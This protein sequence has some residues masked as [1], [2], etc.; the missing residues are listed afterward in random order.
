MID[1][2]DS[3]SVAARWESSPHPVRLVTC[4][5]HH[6]HHH[7]L[8]APQSPELQASTKVKEMPTRRAVT[9]SPVQSI[10]SFRT[11][12]RITKSQTP[13][14]GIK[15]DVISTPKKL[16]AISPP[17][18]DPVPTAPPQQKP[19]QSE[20]EIEEER[21]T[22]S[23]G[24]DSIHAYYENHVLASRV[25]PPVHQEGLPLEEKVL[26]HFDLSL[27]YGPCIGIGR[28][29]RWERAKGLGM[30]PPLEVLAVC[31]KME[32]ELGGTR[33]KEQGGEMVGCGVER[34]RDTRRSYL[35]DF[36]STRTV[37]E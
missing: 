10:L 2:S 25:S 34:T 17:P 31:L 36:L 30:E 26:R 18:A 9:K 21:L 20:Q 37:R 1:T 8:A 28:L 22:T 15:K 29:A 32:K 24:D 27:E 13:H 33:G 11:P 6:R 23:I 7:R 19:A 14:S 12:G 5:Y 3:A 4:P 16:V 35:D